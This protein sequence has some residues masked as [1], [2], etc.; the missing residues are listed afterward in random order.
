M[1]SKRTIAAIGLALSL[2]A[3]KVGPNYKRPSVDVPGEYRG[4]APDATTQPG[5]CWPTRRN[6]SREMQWAAVFQDETLQA[7]IK[8]ALANNYDMRIAATRILQAEANV[9]I[10]R[11][12]QLP[13]INGNGSIVNERNAIYPGAPTFGTLGLSL[14]YIVDFWGQY[15]RATEAARAHVVIHRVRQRGGADDADLGGC[16]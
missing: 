13:S 1:T 12:N 14:N 15:R 7:L 5:S 6:R 8:E 4:V 3:C 2:C 9:G 10:V 11:A 16:Q